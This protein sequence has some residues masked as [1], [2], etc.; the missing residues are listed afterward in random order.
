[1]DASTLSEE[2]AVAGATPSITPG[3]L[4]GQADLTGVKMFLGAGKNMVHRGG[5]RWPR[6]QSPALAGSGPFGCAARFYYSWEVA[7]FLGW[8]RSN[9]G[10]E[11]SG[12]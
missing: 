4:P 9:V 12:T 10:G 1:M 7:G 11:M 5:W 8:W 3:Q 6:L 2:Q